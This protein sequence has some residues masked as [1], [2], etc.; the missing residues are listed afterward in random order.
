IDVAAELAVRVAIDTH[1]DDDRARLDPI[2]LYEAS[3]ADRGD[4]DVRLPRD[5]GK[6]A[7]R[8]VT[9]RHRTA[10]HQELE[11]HRPS[12]DVRLADDHCVLADKILASVAEQGH[13]AVRRA[14][15]EKR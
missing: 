13:A 14:R 9:D 4:E 11:C 2:S 12:D 8:G 3:L 1:V 6:I 10:R 5:A 7:C 15:A